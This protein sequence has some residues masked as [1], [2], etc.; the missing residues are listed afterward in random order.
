MG[1]GVE[2]EDPDE[3]WFRGRRL[4]V[5]RNNQ[6]AHDEAEAVKASRWKRY[7]KKHATLKGVEGG[8]VKQVMEP[9]LGEIRSPVMRNMLGVIQSDNVYTPV[10]GHLS[11]GLRACAPSAETTRP[12]RYISFIGLR[13]P[14]ATKIWLGLRSV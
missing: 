6:L 13:G 14:P 5:R 3:R 2:C 8:R 9:L 7:T 12:P 1:H 11:W 10:G 4:G